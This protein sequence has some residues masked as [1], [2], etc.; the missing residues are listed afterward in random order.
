MS[1]SVQRKHRLVSNL[2]LL[3]V[4]APQTSSR[5]LMFD[6][7]Q[8][9]EHLGHIGSQHNGKYLGILELIAEYNPILSSHI[10]VYDNKG[11]RKP[12]YL[13]SIICEEIIEIKGNKAQENIIKDMQEAKYF[14]L[15]ID[16]ISDI[17]HTNQLT[18][19]LRYVRV[20]D[21]EVAEHFLTFIP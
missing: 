7:I 17:S 12:S 13:S 10:A 4:V 18:V 9:T 21:G 15:S 14:S 5:L 3:M 8:S 11:Q 1:A 20:S 2:H 19:V 16:Y 6:C